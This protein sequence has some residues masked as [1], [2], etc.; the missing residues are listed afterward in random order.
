MSTLL[1]AYL[2]KYSDMTTQVTFDFSKSDDTYSCCRDMYLVSVILCS[3]QSSFCMDF[4]HLDYGPL[5]RLLAF[6]LRKCI[7]YSNVHGEARSTL[8]GKIVD[9]FTNNFA[10]N[11]FLVSI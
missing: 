2:T 6:L 9:S 4:S 10:V 11:L 1:E 8:V 5:Y 7:H 3:S